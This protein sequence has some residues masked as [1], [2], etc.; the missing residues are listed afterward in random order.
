MSHFTQTIKI[1]DNFS[2][3]TITDEGFLKVPAKVARIGNQQYLAGELGLT[4]RNPN[5]I[6][7]VHRPPNEVF[8]KNSL[9]SYKDKDVTIQHPKQFVDADTYKNTSVG[10]VTSVGRQLDSDW[11]EVDLLIKDKYAIDRI[12]NGLCEVSV[13]YS[14]DYKAQDGEYGGEQYEL[15]QTNIKVNHVALV[16]NARAG[17]EARIYDNEINKTKVNIMTK[18]KLD[19]ITVDVN[20][21]DVNALTNLYDSKEDRII[22]LEKQL[23]DAKME[24]EK[25]EKE[26][27]ELKDKMEEEKKKSC[28][29]AINELVNKKSELMNKCHSIDSNFKTDKVHSSAIKR[30]FLK[31][32]DNSIDW[33]Q[34]SDDY[35]E[36]VFDSIKVDDKPEQTND[37]FDG[38]SV[39]RIFD[40]KVND[41]QSSA[42]K[43]QNLNGILKSFGNKG[44]Q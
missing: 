13:G 33:T 37:S 42:P 2:K 28:D 4:D 35:V 17:K 29:S 39:G 11:I 43:G 9:D 44:A 36:G 26:K 10:H 7:I 34:K 12:N 31:V 1:N 24:L 30:E 20:D 25:E 32:H 14:V 15:V 21:S 40:G 18:V 38:E 41:S 3:R 23:A 19:S 8:N 5:D 27:E 6:V 16:D 22:Q